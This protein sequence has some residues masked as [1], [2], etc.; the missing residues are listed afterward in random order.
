MAVVESNRTQRE[1]L[2]VF[3]GGPSVEHEIAVLTGLQ[4]IKAIDQTQYRI[5][6][7]Y[8]APDGKWYTG[9]ELLARSF[10]RNLAANLRQLKQVTML[11]IPGSTDLFLIDSRSKVDSARPIISPSAAILAFH[12]QYGEDGS[13]QGLMEICGLPYVSPGILSASV[14][15]DKAVC[16]A[17]LRG[18]GIPVLPFSV[19]GKA[20]AMRCFGQSVSSLEQSA[21]LGGYPLFVKPCHLGSSIGIGRAC[22]R[23]ELSALLANVFRFDTQAIIEPALQNI[24]EINISVKEGHPPQASVVEVPYSESGILSFEDKYLRDSG[25]KGQG[26]RGMAS[27][28]RAINPKDLDRDVKESVREMALSAF[29]FLNCSGVVRFDFMLDLNTRNIYFNELNTIPGSLAFYLWAESKPRLL[30]T[31]LLSSLV[32]QAKSRKALASS[33]KREVEF[34]A[35]KRD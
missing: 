2:V 6:P 31:E 25:K 19:L 23:S 1:S 3:F 12:G 8:V 33:V 17:A 11:P 24:M 34:R 7:V 29:S 10:Y 32:E 13:F 21:E 22:D 27:L 9:K 4:L 18:I 28:T 15:M 16:K 26:S 20:D 14:A 35:L 5:C 30:Y